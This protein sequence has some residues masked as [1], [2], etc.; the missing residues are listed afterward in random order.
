MTKR[1]YV[2][3]KFDDSVGQENDEHLL[4]I[5]DRFDVAI[6]KVK[7]FIRDG[8]KLYQFSIVL[9]EEGGEST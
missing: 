6:D 2:Y 4:L 9:E 3:G 7:A 1:I 8:L 5:E